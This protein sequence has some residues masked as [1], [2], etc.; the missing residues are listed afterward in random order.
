MSDM[1]KKRILT[2]GEAM[3]LFVA[4][5]PA[6]FLRS[7]ISSAGSLAQTPMSPLAWPDWAF[8]CIG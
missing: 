1:Q 7:R 3:A 5:K 6:T 8:K 2:F 4:D